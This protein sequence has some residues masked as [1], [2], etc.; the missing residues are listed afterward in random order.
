[1]IPRKPDT[2][3]NPEGVTDKLNEAKK[4]EKIL[5]KKPV[6]VNNYTVVLR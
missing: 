6:R 1:M 4:R 5:N 2:R 3:H